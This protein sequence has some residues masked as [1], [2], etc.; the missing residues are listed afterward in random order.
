MM[1]V[2]IGRGLSFYASESHLRFQYTFLPSSIYFY[3]SG[4]YDFESQAYIISR[5]RSTV[6]PLTKPYLSLLL[7]IV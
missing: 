4:G 7:F 2:R 1:W 3:D 5:L 6:N